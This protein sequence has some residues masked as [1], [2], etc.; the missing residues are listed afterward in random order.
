[1]QGDVHTDDFVQVEHNS[2]AR[3]FLEALAERIDLVGADG[4]FQE[5]VLPVRAGLHFACCV[6]GLVDQGHR[7]TRHSTATGVHYRA[8]DAA[9]G[10]LRERQ[11]R[12]EAECQRQNCCE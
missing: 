9:A 8:A 12:R 11:G 6:R 2:F 1:M 4:H 7:C 5:D 10:T 3:V